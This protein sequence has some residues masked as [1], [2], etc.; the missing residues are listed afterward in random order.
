MKHFFATCYLLLAT[1]LHSATRYSLLAT[2]SQKGFTIFELIIFAGI[3]TLIVVAFIT[4]LVSITRVHV[5]QSAAAEVNQ[6]SQF[7]LQTVQYYV[8][9]SSLIELDGNAATS[10]LKLR[11]AATSSDPLY[12]YA[13]AGVLYLKETDSGTP[14]ALTSSKVTV[15]N[16][17]FTKREHARASDSVSVSFTIAYNTV[18]AQERF[19]ETLNTAVAR[20]NAATF[21]SNLIPSST[22]LYDVGVTS[23]IWRSVNNIIYFSGAN[24]GVG[25][26]NPGQTLE[27]NGGVRL[28][29]TTSKPTCDADQRGTFWVT[30]ASGGVKDSVEVCAKSA[31]DSYAWR[32]IY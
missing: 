10:T 29:T 21:D 26:S 11:M 28:N 9:Q 17:S 27:V 15:S 6:Q 23:Q 16:I 3:L 4:I 13:S 31:A 22:A 32:T 5:R 18:N 1:R 20:V 19:S 7:V 25:V 12:I 14:V 30:Q 24:V 8:E 2:R